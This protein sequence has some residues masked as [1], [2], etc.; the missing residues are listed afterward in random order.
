MRLL[1]RLLIVFIAFVSLMVGA[2]VLAAYLIDVPSLIKKYQ[3][4]ALE[5]AST[6]LNR[7]VEAGLV[8][9]SWWPIFGVHVE[10]LRI[11]Q[12]PLENSLPV[13][14]PSEQAFVNLG[15][16]EIGVAVWPALTSLGHDIHISKIR[17]ERPKVHIIRFADGHYNFESIGTSSSSTTTPSSGD[18]DSTGLMERLERARVEE[19]AIVEGHIRFEDRTS[20]PPFNFIIN[21]LGFV[22]RN[23]GLGL[24]LEAVLTAAVEDS[25]VPHV[26]VRLKTKPLPDTL[27]SF[28]APEVESIDIE[29]IRLPWSLPIEVPSVAIRKAELNSKIHISNTG[30]GG[31]RIDGPLELSHLRL[32]SPGLRAGPEFRIKL[33][34]QVETSTQFK[35]IRLSGTTFELGPL[36]SAINGALQLSPAL[37]W[38]DISIATPEPLSVQALAAL[39]PGEPL[40]VPSGRVRLNAEAQGGLDENTVSLQATWSGFSYAQSD[41]SAKG[42]IVLKASLRGSTQQ[43]T[44]KL[45]INITPLAVKGAGYEKPKSV[46]AE[47]KLNGRVTN[48]AVRIGKSSLQLA[49]AKITSEGVYSLRPRGKIDIQMG[50][51]TV[52]LRPF[53]ST[54]KI[55]AETVPEGAKLGLS[56]RYR[57]SASAPAE[58]R[59][60]IPRI[61]FSAGRSQLTGNA[62][63]QSLAPLNVQVV[64][65]SP[66]LDLDALMPSAEAAE[67][68]PPPE[69]APNE[70]I[71]PP[72]YA[73]AEVGVRLAVKKLIYQKVLMTDANLVLEL[74]KGQLVLKQSTLKLLGGQFS[75]TGTRVNLKKAQ[76][77]YTLRA[78]ID[79]VQGAELINKFVGLGKGLGG[80]LTTDL[81]FKGR[82]LDTQNITQS[83]SGDLSMLMANGKLDG[84]NM[85]TETLGPLGQ[86]LQAANI[87]GLKLSKVAAT[88]FSR[89]RGSFTLKNGQANLKAPMVMSTS[90]GDIRFTGGVGIDGRL[91]LQASFGVNPPIIRT[92]TKGKVRLRQPLP[93]TFRL[94]CT[95]MKP[96]IQGLNVRSAAET[97][98][99]AY[100]G[101]AIDKLTDPYKR[102]LGIKDKSSGKA[103]AVEDAAKKAAERALKDLFK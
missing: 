64:A 56:L 32:T 47:L 30:K 80:E 62:S 58:G 19:I 11:G 78:K 18:S 54:L 91:A 55:P 20:G 22:T 73:D 40:S 102:K 6:A 44:F 5:A 94:G 100:A 53:L 52:A 24:P 25:G 95:M 26:K 7:K 76:P 71:L 49:Q 13:G 35:A 48:S 36:K 98:A 23:V 31:L 65:R 37:T 29:T 2:L 68:T 27:A 50:L 3:P 66:Y 51:D 83:L 75:G 81:S 61:N 60:D 28:G 9:P 14:L 86:A 87:G 67:D 96:C 84:V 103:K 92:L 12:E 33:G 77:D 38:K 93:I 34:L 89:L 99:K 72:A 10:N 63:V 85:V 39:A 43:P 1:R 69:P 46:A 90:R 97:I 57:A 101:R 59:I 88:E 79:R 4:M 74:V 45:G 70:A 8:T 42:S 21:N 41:L 82:G 15:A 17:L 16:A